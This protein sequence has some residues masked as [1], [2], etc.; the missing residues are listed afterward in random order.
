MTGARQASAVR[1]AAAHEIP[2]IEAVAVAAYAEYRAEVPAPVFDA[3][4]EDLRCLADHWRDA[5]VLVAEVDGRI[6]GSVLF[7]PD[8]GSE[9]LGLPSGWAG[10]RKLAVLPEMRGRGLGRALTEACIAAARR[11]RAPTV[12][13]HTTPFM[14]AARRMY[15]AI[16]F[17]RC[18]EFD[19]GTADMG[20]GDADRAPDILA[21][22]LDLNG[23]AQ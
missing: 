7:Y 23:E 19:I 14:P 9:G 22:R 3:Y 6:A 10:F 4:L 16:G 2:E 1:R 12:G 18:P 21:Y 13:I 15:E 5:E 20:L 8:A 11:C 17:R